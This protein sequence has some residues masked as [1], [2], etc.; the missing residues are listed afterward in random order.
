MKSNYNEINILFWNARDL[1]NFPEFQLLLKHENIHIALISET[2]LK[3]D[4]KI[5]L[6]NYT[7]YR[8]DNQ[9]EVLQ[10]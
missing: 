3:P 6:H 8:N 9:N 7:T 10:F 1:S 5:F 4:N 2:L